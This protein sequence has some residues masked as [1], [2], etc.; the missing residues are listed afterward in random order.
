M[1][2]TD[3]ANNTSETKQPS[4]QDGSFSKRSSLLV[5]PNKPGEGFWY[6]THSI[7]G[8]EYQTAH[9]LVQ[10]IQS[11][12]LDDRVFEI[13]VPTQEKIVV[14]SGRKRKIQERLFPG[15]IMIR[16]VLDDDTWHAVSDT[17]GVTGFVGI[18]DRPQPLPEEEAQSILRFGEMEALKFEAAFELGDGVKIKDGPFTDFFGKV[19]SIDNDKGKV[20]VLVNVFGRETPLEL[21]FV[22]VERL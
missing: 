2:D 17:S 8:R 13:L 16:M 15:Y 3:Q 4:K 5:N 14:S 11:L 22:R 7:S 10:K 20:N 9:T 12:G 1:S 21:D 19:E 6:I 18:G